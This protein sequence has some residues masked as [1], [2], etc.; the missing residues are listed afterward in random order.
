MSEQ[1]APPLVLAWAQVALG[2]LGL[3]GAL[4]VDPAGRVLLWPAA[5]ALVVMGLRDVLLR[6]TLL[7]EPDALTVIDGLRR[8]QTPWSELADASVVTDRRAPLLQLDLTDTV[9]V[10]SRHRLGTTPSQALEQL[11][12]FRAQRR[13]T[14]GSG[15][16]L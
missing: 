8:R 12:A 5:A 15:H 10:L 9:V 6:P 4:T 3:V 11:E 2:C 16:E 1:L 13:P 7:L 14:R